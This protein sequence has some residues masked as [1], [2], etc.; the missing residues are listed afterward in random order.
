MLPPPE[1]NPPAAPPAA[2]RPADRAAFWTALL[3]VLGCFVIFLVILGIAYLPQ[4]RK[5]PQVDLAKIPAEDQWKYTPE[6]RI[7]RLQEMRVREK[8]AGT[9]TWIDRSKGVVQLPIERAMELT[10]QELNAA[11]KP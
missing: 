4:L 3:A 5:A 10:R 7:A 1:N 8:A 11:R 2:T 6:G 9:Y